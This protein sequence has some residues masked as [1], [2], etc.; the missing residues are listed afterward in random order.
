MAQL[1]DT[2]CL[3][4]F[5]CCGL[6]VQLFLPRHFAATLTAAGRP[7]VAAV[8]TSVTGAAAPDHAGHEYA[9]PQLDLRKSAAR[10]APQLPIIRNYNKQC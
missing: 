5:E 6:A 7:D 2:S 9:L 4:D 10:A 3:V 8:G 1:N